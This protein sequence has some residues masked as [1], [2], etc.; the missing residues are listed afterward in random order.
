MC[1]YYIFWAPI[2]LLK[3]ISQLLYVPFDTQRFV[4]SYANAFHNLAKITGVLNGTV[5]TEQPQESTVRTI[6]FNLVDSEE[7]SEVHE[8]DGIVC[9]R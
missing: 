6:G 1:L 9:K 4:D 3:D 7:A 5:Q 8:M 2:A